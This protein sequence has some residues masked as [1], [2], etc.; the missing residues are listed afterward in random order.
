[1]L[2]QGDGVMEQ[3]FRS[4]I[5]SMTPITAQQNL[6]ISSAVYNTDGTLASAS[7]NNAPYTFSYSRR[8]LTTVTGGG[9]TKTLTWSSDRLQSVVTS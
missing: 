2:A 4:V 3:G 7:I 9:V 8:K 1:M 5:G 6:I